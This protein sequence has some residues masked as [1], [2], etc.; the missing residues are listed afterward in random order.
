MT[1]GRTRR[2]A[3]FSAWA[4]GRVNLIGEHTDYSGGLVLPAAVE[5]GITLEVRSAARDVLLSSEGYGR[6]EFPADGGSR[7]ATGWRRYPQAVAT[8]LAA[9]GRPAVGFDGTLSSDLPAGAGLSSS[10]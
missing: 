7:S 4:P 1:A 6:A 9:L 8:E 5:L 2:E 3:A 10:A